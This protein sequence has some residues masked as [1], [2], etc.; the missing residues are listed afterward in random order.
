MARKG[1]LASGQRRRRVA[2]FTLIEVIIV[3]VIVGVLMMAVLPSYQESMRKGRRADAKAG[4]MT[5]ANREESFMLD[6]GTYT[7]DMTQLGFTDDP[8]ITEEG[9]YEVAAAPEDSDEFQA[10]C[11]D[12]ATIA[13][14]YVLIATPVEDGAQAE[15]TRC[16]RLLLDSTGAKSA[17]GTTA[18]ECW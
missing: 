8:M 2:G 17:E 11:P 12:D 4:L 10:A 14:C 9:H 16:T 3:V 13:N 5:A 1:T 15:D 18:D 7:L 6:R